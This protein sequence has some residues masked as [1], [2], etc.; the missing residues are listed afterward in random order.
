MHDLTGTRACLAGKDSDLSI[1]LQPGL[2][3]KSNHGKA[4]RNNISA[5]TIS[6]YG[7]HSGGVTGNGSQLGWAHAGILQR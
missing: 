2:A 4:G 6:P 1:L 3:S 5:F 7:R